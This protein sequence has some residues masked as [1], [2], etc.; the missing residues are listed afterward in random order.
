MLSKLVFFITY[1]E[2]PAELAGD[3]GKLGE[4][5]VWTAGVVGRAEVVACCGD[6]CADEGAPLVGGS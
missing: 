5:V 6:D 3:C 2:L 4:V 1:G